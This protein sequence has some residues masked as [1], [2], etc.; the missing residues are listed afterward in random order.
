M[1]KYIVKVKS[2]KTNPDGTRMICG[3]IRR[4]GEEEIDDK[5]FIACDGQDHRYP[6]R[7]KVNWHG[8][9]P[10]MPKETCTT[11]LFDRGE[12]VSIAMHLNGFA[13]R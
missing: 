8:P 1:A 6:N 2:A 5:P 10:R 11:N 13:P 3:T 7:V 4:T 9:N 12:R